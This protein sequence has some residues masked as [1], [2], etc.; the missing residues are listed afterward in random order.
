MKSL[1]MEE[2][3]N[4]F[5]ARRDAVL[6]LI[7]LGGFWGG[8]AVLLIAADAALPSFV[9]VVFSGL[10]IACAFLHMSTT[11]K[12]EGRLTGRPVRPW[13]FGYA[14]FRTQVIATLPST[15]RAAAQRQQRIPCW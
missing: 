7:G 15:V 4:L 12:F 1:T 5:P 14:S 10:A 6:Y 13:P 2:P 8:V 3:D 11:R 9:V